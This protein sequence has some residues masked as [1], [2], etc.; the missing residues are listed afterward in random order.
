[1]CKDL[2]YEKVLEKGVRTIC[3]EDLCQ[4]NGGNI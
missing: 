4:W 1:M 2:S 3:N